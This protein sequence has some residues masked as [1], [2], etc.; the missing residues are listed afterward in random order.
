MCDPAH[1]NHSFFFA[2]E[3]FRGDSND[4]LGVLAE[5]AAVTNDSLVFF[6]SRGLSNAGYADAMRASLF[7]LVPVGDTPT[8]RR[9]F[10]AIASGCIPVYLGNLTDMAEATLTGESNLPFRSAISWS[11][12][13][14]PA[15][16][17]ACLKADEFAGARTLGRR[18][19]RLAKEMDPSTF[20]AGC[21]HRLAVF[22]DL[23][24]FAAPED[25]D[26]S[27]LGTGAATGLLLQLYAQRIPP[28]ECPFPSPPL[29]PA[30]PLSP[31]SP[32]L[33]VSPL[34]PPLSPSSPPPQL[35]PLPPPP[36]TPLALSPQLQQLHS[37]ALSPPPAP[38][39]RLPR[40]PGLSLRNLALVLTA[41]A[42]TAA[43]VGAMS[44]PSLL[45]RLRG[46]SRQRVPRVV[47]VPA[48]E[49]G[50][51]DLPERGSSL[52][53]ARRVPTCPPAT[54]LLSPEAQRSEDQA[55]LTEL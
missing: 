22:D 8:S 5:M 39:S 48:T 17:M 36:S 28:A 38:Q 10:D 20:K 12:L 54:T 16:S 1:R 25:G 6:G 42:M 45:R 50:G 51:V 9:L 2:G 41:A 47:Q 26:A 44:T 35:S 34:P 13:V 24:S 46:W 18:L 32:P 37:P 31:L 40:A 49:E 52:S 33:S 43:A 4:R 14:L 55:E 29:S 15:G 21:Q 23:L 19:E 11:S 30:P 53:R 3:M 7:C 27:R